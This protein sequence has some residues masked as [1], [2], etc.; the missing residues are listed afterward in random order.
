MNRRKK[1]L[2]GA[3][4]LLLLPI[5]AHLSID[6]VVRVSPPPI[7]VPKLTRNAT[8]DVVRSGKGFAR[9]REHL[10]EV[11]LEGAPEEIG[12]QQASLL[13]EAM[14][15]N[16]QIVW[17]G[18]EDVVPMK[19]ARLFFF[20]VGRV[21]YRN[22]GENIPARYRR[23]IAAQAATFQPDPYE[24]KLPTYERMTMLHALYD[25]ALGFEGAPMIGC[26][27]FVLGPTATR[28]GH[29]LFGRAFD[30][31]LADVFD[32]DKAVHFVKGE[33]VLPFASVAWPGLVGVLTA[34]NSE[35]VTVAVN[36]GRAGTPSTKGMPVVFS[37]R[38]VME[39]AHSTKEAVALLVEEPVMVSH[40]VIV[41]DGSGETAIVE[42]APGLHAS[43]LT[44]FADASRVAVT[45]HFEGA[46]A[47]DPK[48]VH[49]KEK[50]TTLMRRAR[51]DERLREV[52]DHSADPATAL[53]ILRDHTCA[54]GVVCPPGD[55]RAVDAF[56]ATHGVIADAT[57]RTLWVSAGPH[58]SGKFVRFDLNTVFK[59]DGPLESPIET[60]PEDGALSNGKYTEGRARA[61][62]PLFH[63]KRSQ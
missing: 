40:I 16:E 31:E 7:V 46:Y 57:S 41:T 59:S 37:L 47:N 49:V 30:I 8:A 34:M 33:G 9:T 20:D 2:L 36:G 39:R 1:V 32:S 22:V 23:E 29:T 43:V 3:L 21:R 5:G 45:N 63:S 27:A 24:A 61:G 51:L 62:G 56:I 53:S 55:R 6:S 17:D 44:Q 10:R 38:N 13:Y 60:L 14:V 25:I 50:T 11:H 12:A 58:L 52:G 18:F 48:N 28:D 19:A 42:R 4:A 15:E 26:S 35:G 54:G